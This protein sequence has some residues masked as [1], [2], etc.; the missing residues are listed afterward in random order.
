MLK[1]AI[2]YKE[3]LAEKA[4]VVIDKPEKYQFIDLCNYLC[5]NT[6]DVDEVDEYVR[7]K[8]VS[9]NANGDVLG[10]M[11][12]TICRQDNSVCELLFVN[13]DLTKLSITFVRDMEAFLQYLLKNFRKVSFQC[14]VGNPAERLY[15]KVI[16][17]YHG[18]V[19]GVK[20]QEALLQ[21]GQFYDLK[22]YEIVKE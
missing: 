19:V 11:K 14:V 21:D 6:F 5:Y 4:K 12:A 9:I 7:V 15:D 22:L 10:F 8:R 17:K 20:K 18:R 3:A 16:E 2:L 1:P 13:F